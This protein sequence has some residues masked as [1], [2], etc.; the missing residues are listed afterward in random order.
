MA[1]AFNRIK[2]LKVRGPPARALAGP[3]SHTRPA[4]WP[5][6]LPG[7]GRKSDDAPA[8][9]TPSTG[10]AASPARPPPPREPAFTAPHPATAATAAAP[11]A[12]ATTAGHPAG[13][14][15]GAA[16][17]PL[18]AAAAAAMDTAPAPR[19]S[20]PRRAAQPQEQRLSD[21]ALLA[22]LP[23]GFH[24]A[25]Y[26]ASAGVLAALPADFTAWGPL[27]PVRKRKFQELQAVGTR[28]AALLLSHHAE[29]VRELMRVSELQVELKQAQDLCTAERGHLASHHK[30]VEVALGIVHKQRRRMALATILA[31]CETIDTLR[32]AERKLA[33]LLDAERYLDAI[34][35]GANCKEMV[36]AFSRYSC[37]TE[38]AATLGDAPATIEERLNEAL[39]R[40]CSSFTA[41]TYGEIVRAYV[42]LGG[43]QAALDRLTL[44]FVTAVQN[45]TKTVLNKYAG[46][47]PV[48]MAAVAAV[49]SALF[50]VA[51]VV[52]GDKD[53]DTGRGN[54]AAAAAGGGGGAGGAGNTNAGQAAAGNAAPV[55]EADEPRSQF[56]QLVGRVPPRAQIS[57]LVELCEML[58]SL[59][60]NFDSMAAWHVS[61]GATV[62]S[63]LD[64]AATDSLKK[65]DG[66]AVTE[67]MLRNRLENGR[68]RVWQDV[69][70]H[71]ALCLE[72][73]AVS[74]VTA[75][76]F[77]LLLGPVRLLMEIGQ[78]FSGQP[79]AIL[80]SV[81]EK[82]SGNFLNVF[83][84][85]AIG[86]LREHLRGDLWAA[87]SLPE[88]LLLCR[89]S[90]LGWESGVGN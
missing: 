62:L 48:P 13:H 40:Q 35:L 70:R 17:V 37:V 71:V 10:S 22:A 66:G 15:A 87:C 46:P 81:V 58:C 74:D 23:E 76:R 3:Y 63:A 24:A 20:K 59:M 50:A 68:R 61:Q 85:Q 19:A 55:P 65:S 45:A 12:A 89:C 82:V 5:L 32:S 1:A 43:F 86:A 51:N 29:F 88:V 21:E 53:K 77:L 79:P 80:E 41:K 90:G 34:E 67:E 39:A 28:L 75:D 16:P 6:Q 26:D 11:A 18:S 60:L 42:R 64:E 69:Q 52:T 83:Q 4:A 38:L 31:A 73:F 84:N 78:D 47:A 56:K 8:S 57:S 36:A 25:D 72:R 7:L 44:H 9:P 49:S 33:E 27:E 2:S 14:P 30:G 54:A